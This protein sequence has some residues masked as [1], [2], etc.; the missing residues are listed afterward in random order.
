MKV[1]YIGDY[2]SP[3]K[4]TTVFGYTFELGE[5]KDIKDDYVIGKLT[6][7]KTFQVGTYKKD[8]IAE[9]VRSMTDDE[10]RGVV[11]DNGLELEDRKKSTVIKAVIEFLKEDQDK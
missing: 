4:K 6:N 7:N 2:D 5:T 10:L 9:K 11:L 1:T 3:P 8:P